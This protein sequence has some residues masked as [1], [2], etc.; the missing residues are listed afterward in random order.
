MTWL[1]TADSYG[2]IGVTFF[3]IL[4]GFVL[5]WSYGRRPARRF[6]WLR[7]ARVYPTQ[8]V[9]AIFAFV[10]LASLERIPSL[11]GRIADVLL[12]QAWSTNPQVYYGGNGVSW[13]L[14]A[15]AF[16]YALFPLA[17]LLVRRMHGRGIAI[18]AVV[19]LATMAVAPMIAASAG[20]SAYTYA[21]AFFVFPPYRFGEFL[22]GM[23]LCQAIQR[24][25]RIPAPNTVWLV[26]LVGF[27]GI[28]WWMVA[29]TLSTYVAVSRPYVALAYLPIFALMLAAG[30]SADLRGIRSWLASPVLI[31]LGEWSF[32]LY[33]V[34]KP[35]YLLTYRWG[36]WGTPTGTTAFIEFIVYLA[37]AVAVAA[38]VHYTVEKPVERLL[39]RMPIGQPAIT[40][41]DEKQTER[42]RVPDS[43]LLSPS[44]EI[45]R[46]DRRGESAVAGW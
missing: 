30:A 37:L 18:T 38:A 20:M 34:H 11:S 1:L 25:L 45:L 31:K 24:G 21:W 43:P 4:S 27:G 7:F 17:I 35:V 8:F 3:F 44:Q 9:V 29:R 28:T 14:S 42:R 12:V 41:S 39:R 16:F 22:L 13:S 36:W 46:V 6:W 2:Y 26:A 10:V 33:L 15:E 23:L 5:T 32:A 19:T 40:R